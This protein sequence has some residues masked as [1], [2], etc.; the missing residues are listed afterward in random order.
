MARF[1]V[2]LPML[3]LHDMGAWL[4][5]PLKWMARASA[6]VL[7][8]SHNS[9]KDCPACHMFSPQGH[10]TREISPSDFLRVAR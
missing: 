5:S 8:S 3:H 1:I 4:I 7:K 10:I 6:R 9:K 2:R